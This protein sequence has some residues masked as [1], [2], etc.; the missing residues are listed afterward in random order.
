MQQLPVGR[1]AHV[2]G[3]N[4]HVR[5]N[6]KRD[7]LVM[8]VTVHYCSVCVC[9]C[10]SQR[11]ATLRE[12]EPVLDREAM[13]NDVDSSATTQRHTTVRHKRQVSPGKTRNLNRLQRSSCASERARS[14]RGPTIVDTLSRITAHWDAEWTK[15]AQ[16]G[17]RGQVGATAGTS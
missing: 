3:R 6:T 1:V 9:V 10:C 12:L 14:G 5:L 7:Y 11:G 13:S 2:C 4:L 16:R 15:A 17:P 8:G